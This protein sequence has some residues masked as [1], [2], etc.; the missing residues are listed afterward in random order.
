M[1]HSSKKTSSLSVVVSIC[2]LTILSWFALRPLTWAGFFPMHDDTQI[3]RVA[4]MKNA[5]SQGQFPV[6][7]VS[8]LGYGYGYPI[9]NFYGPLPYYAGSIFA[10]LGFSALIATKIMFGIGI[11]LLGWTTFALVASCWGSI[12]GLTAGVLVMY[13]PYHAVQIY[14]R[15]AVGEFW[16]SAFIP[17]IMLGFLLVGS[18][19]S[20]L[21][22]VLI[23]SIGLAA[24]ILSHT[25]SGFV[26]I[27]SCFIFLFGYVGY[28]FL[29]KSSWDRTVF[30][31]YVGIISFGLG[32]SVFFWLPAFTEM[33]FTS[34]AGQIGSSASY[35][36]HFVCLSQFW[37]SPWGFGGSTPG[38]VDGLS[39]KLGK[40]HILL[41]LIGFLLW[42]RA[43]KFHY[44]SLY[45]VA[46]GLVVG[47]VVFATAISTPLWSILP[48]FAYIQYPWRFITV[49]ELGLAIFATSLVLQKSQVLSGG[50]AASIIALTMWN[51]AY[52]FV[53][54]YSYPRAD[55]AFVTQEEIRFRISKISDEYLPSA[56]LRP[57]SQSEVVFD[58]IEATGAALVTKVRD[59]ATYAVYR[60]SSDQSL[61]VRI[62]KAYFPGWRYW[63]NDVEVYPR[64]THGL[65]NI[66]LPSGLTEITIRFIDTPV[67]IVGNVL[68][69]GFVVALFFYYGKSKKTIT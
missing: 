54:Q 58:T 32:L 34:V 64:I 60:I 11:L 6:R 65:P 3:A 28:M 17:V 66:T 55:K 51:N 41:A 1:E 69:V 50:I 44:N 39:F 7:W 67:R 2:V 26:A 20:R 25:L 4:V 36:D 63:V 31:S 48:Q 10:H 40:I 27:V 62:N 61:N 56:V 47:G 52:L 22:G 13:A 16:A 49:I 37:S 30:L 53:P 45:I 57:T 43:K 33:Q 68:S 19:R 15:G 21:K 46:I 24:I 42:I 38:C 14:V 59:E 18:V 29:N 35:K 5:I 8:D 23:G 9:Y 12:A